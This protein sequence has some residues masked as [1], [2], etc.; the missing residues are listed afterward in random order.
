[1]RRECWER[2]AFLAFF[3]I[4]H[5]VASVA[6]PGLALFPLMGDLRA[7]ILVWYTRSI[8]VARGVV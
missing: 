1:M 6:V 7:G 3:G 2:V 4:K 5:R 8:S